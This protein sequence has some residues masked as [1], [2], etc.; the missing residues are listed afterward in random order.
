MLGLVQQ[1]WVALLERELSAST[2]NLRL[3]PVRKL[4]HDLSDN[5]R[6]DPVV[7]A[8]I[9]RAKGVKYRECIHGLPGVFCTS[10]SDGD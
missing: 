9:G 7:A 4:A 5:G 8:T 2:I 3:S 6:L 1:S 10:L